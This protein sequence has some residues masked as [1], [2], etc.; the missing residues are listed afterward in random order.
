MIV[1]VMMTIIMASKTLASL[2]F[3][4]AI[5]T[6]VSATL[7]QTNTAPSKPQITPEMITNGKCWSLKGSP[8]SGTPNLI[9]PVFARPTTSPYF[10]LISKFSTK[11]ASELAQKVLSSKV[12]DQ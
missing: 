6:L 11:V 8:S 12:K 9:K 1:A 3:K 5:L 4:Q 2:F 10:K 7:P